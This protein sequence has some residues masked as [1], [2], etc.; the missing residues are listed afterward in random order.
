MKTKI[1]ILSK[2][3]E[4]RWFLTRSLPITDETGHV[5]RWIGTSTDIHERNA[6]EEALREEKICSSFCKG[7]E[8]NQVSFQ[9]VGYI[10]KSSL[11]GMI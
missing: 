9:Q 1:R 2:T 11:P 4:Y 10:R 6:A 7:P 5:T 8:V 3:G